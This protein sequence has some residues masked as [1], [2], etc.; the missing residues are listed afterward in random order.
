MSTIR[1]DSFPEDRA[2]GN[3]AAVVDIGGTKVAAG[4]VTES[5]HLLHKISIPT[6]Q[7]GAQNVLDT[8]LALVGSEVE[9]S[10]QEVVGIGV[11]VA[12]AVDRSTG[13]V[14][15][16]PNI[17]GWQDIPLGRLLREATNLPVMVG[18]DGHLTALGEHWKG[19]GE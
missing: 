18:F 15:W 8:V 10:E 17:A 19:A 14:R 3:I 13:G 16:A 7:H 5:G 6:D 12:G 9:R 1:L 2:P 11:S 4:L